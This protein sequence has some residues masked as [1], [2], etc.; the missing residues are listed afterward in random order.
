MPR[1]SKTIVVSLTSDRNADPGLYVTTV[2]IEYRN[3]KLVEQSE[4]IGIQLLGEAKLSIA[5]KKFK[6]EIIKAGMPFTLTLKRD[7][8]VET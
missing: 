6:P 4:E 5:Q 2:N 7:G 8:R 1:E 3:P